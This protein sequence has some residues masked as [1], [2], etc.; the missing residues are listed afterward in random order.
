MD[1]IPARPEIGTTRLNPVQDPQI[2][3]ISY[4]MP[5]VTMRFASPAAS[6][7]VTPSLLELIFRRK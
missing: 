1:E 6:P 2:L 4:A 5:L 3:P 7:C